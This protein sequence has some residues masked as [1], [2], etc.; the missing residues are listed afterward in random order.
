MEVL[1]H[2]EGGEKTPTELSGEMDL[3]ISSVSKHLKELER[4]GLVV[5]SGKKKGKTRSYLKYRL[6]D[7]VYFVSSLDGEVGKEMV[8]LDE[9]HK[10]RFRIWSIP[11]KR[12]HK[13]LDKF[14]CEVQKDLE[15]I[16]SLMVYG[17]VARG[18]AGEDSDVDLLIISEFE[19]LEDKYGANVVGKKMFMANVFSRAD[20]KGSLE[21]GSEFAENAIEEGRIIYDPEGFL[22]EMKNG[23]KG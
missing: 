6:R 7:F 13:H 5:K 3:S 8:E 10:V 11:Q 21:E 16:D 9:H 4:M 23:Y 14:W 17:S 15:K 18:D 1:N 20:F 22:R 19:N 12:F 2:L